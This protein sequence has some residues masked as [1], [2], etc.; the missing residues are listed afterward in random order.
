MLDVYERARLEAGYRATYFLQMLSELGGLETARQLLASSSPSEGF[1][2][3]WER[4]RLDLTV[5]AR[6]IKPEYEPLFTEDERET[7]RKRL[8][9]LG[10][11]P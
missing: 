11:A 2:A 7:A 1:T 8:N 4:Q 6:V 5:E 10:Y 9:D 3:L